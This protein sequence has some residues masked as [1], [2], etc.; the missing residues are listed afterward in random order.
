MSILIAVHASKDIEDRVGKLKKYLEEE[1]ERK[2]AWKG[3]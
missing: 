3:R 1:F 2:G